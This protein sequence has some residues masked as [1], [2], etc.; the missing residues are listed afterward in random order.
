[1]LQISVG[2]GWVPYIVRPLVGNDDPAT[3]S[4]ATA[5][6]RAAHWRPPL[7]FSTNAAELVAAAG[8][9]TAAARGTDGGGGAAPAMNRLVAL[10]FLLAFFV[11][12]ICLMGVVHAILLDEFMV[13]M[14]EERQRLNEEEIDRRCITSEK[15]GSPLDPLLAS[16]AHFHSSSDLSDKI[17]EL[18]LMID[19][20]GRCAARRVCGRRPRLRVAISTESRRDA[21]ATTPRGAARLRQRGGGGKGVNVER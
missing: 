20:N 14:Q 5:S 21:L 18:Y 12:G 3:E 16:L 4:S 13:A 7:P 6:V 9:A 10:F 15:L 19:A 11:A 17:K 8:T 1:M 2:D